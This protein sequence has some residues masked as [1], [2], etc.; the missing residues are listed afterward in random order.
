MVKRG[1]R[2]VGRWRS[3]EALWM[4]QPQGCL[5]FKLQLQPPRVN[6]V[7]GA[8]PIRVFGIPFWN[9]SFTV[10]IGSDTG[11]GPTC[12]CP[13]YNAAQHVTC[14]IVDRMQ[15]DRC[16]LS[17]ERASSDTQ[18]EQ[19]RVLAILN[20]PEQAAR[21]LRTL[22]DAAALDCVNACFLG[23][24]LP[25]LH[26]APHACPEPAVEYQ[27][28]R[29]RA[30]HNPVCQT[31]HQPLAPSAHS[32]GG[33]THTLHADSKSALSLSFR[34]SLGSTEYGVAQPSTRRRRGHSSP[35]RPR[36]VRLGDVSIRLASVAAARRPIGGNYA[37]VLG[38]KPHGENLTGTAVIAA[39]YSSTSPE[40]TRRPSGSPDHIAA[41]CVRVKPTTGEEPSREPVSRAIRP[42]VYRD[43]EE[44]AAV[45]AWG[46]DTL[47]DVIAAAIDDTLDA[48]ITQSRTATSTAEAW[49]DVV[50]RML[51]KYRIITQNSCSISG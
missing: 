3:R 38:A 2:Y 37:L 47:R 35:S 22:T 45:S 43:A 36:D 28:P 21:V 51:R 24:L 48:E 33:G 16:A 15:R 20:D 13:K 17:N 1:A 27:P 30:R 32:L 19:Q 23:R 18:A 44:L 9:A 41:D 14:T 31:Q 12:Q 5:E 26:A 4:V 39:L 29:R 34:D 40:P 25:A 50:P 49:C 11:E 6:F 10:A 8:K 7:T 42:C 46:D